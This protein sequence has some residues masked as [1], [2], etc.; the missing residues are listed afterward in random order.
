M[1]TEKDH[2]RG[3]RQ[4][5]WKAS[6][7]F[8]RQSN[9]AVKST[10]DE[11]LAW[12]GMPK[13]NWLSERQRNPEE[14]SK[15]FRPISVKVGSLDAM[16]AYV[17]AMREPV[18]IDEANLKSNKPEKSKEATGEK[19]KASPQLAA[20]EDL[21][22]GLLGA[23]E[24]QV[25]Q[26][27]LLAQA[28]APARGQSQSQRGLKDPL[29]RTPIDLKTGAPAGQPNSGPAL[30]RTPVGSDDN[31]PM[32]QSTLMEGMKRGEAFRANIRER[33]GDSLPSGVNGL[34][35]YF[36]DMVQTRWGEIGPSM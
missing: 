33:F 28:S 19:S 12:S 7:A 6:S 11:S 31:T 5:S 26:S 3:T 9:L 36:L 18:P 32:E 14:Q 4:E 1:G 10:P 24:Q 34:P 22:T 13:E 25:P 35:V 29:V 21:T 16:E 2:A 23:E 15:T 30:N 17:F 20:S 27:Q 8:N